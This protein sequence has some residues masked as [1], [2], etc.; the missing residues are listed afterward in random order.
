MADHGDAPEPATDITDLYIFQK[1]GD[2]T[3]SIFVMNVNP[4]APNQATLFD[5]TRATS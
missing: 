1:P 4:D 5:R 3:K 2:P